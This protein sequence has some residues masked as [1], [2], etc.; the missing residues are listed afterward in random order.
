MTASAPTVFEAPLRVPP[1]PTVALRSRVARRLLVRAVRRLPE[2][3]LTVRDSDGSL[4]VRGVDDGPELHILRD[5]FYHRLGAAG[6]IGFGEA[7]MAGEWAA[8]GDLASVLR[9]FAANLERLI[10]PLLQ[11]AGAWSSHS[12]RERSATRSGGRRATSAAI[13]TSRTSCS[14]CSS[15]R[16]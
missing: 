16:R 7:Y 4:L 12:S 13:T 10:P 6:K 2:Q 3:S 11:K 9:P 15:T 1:P 14:H 8:V 5:A